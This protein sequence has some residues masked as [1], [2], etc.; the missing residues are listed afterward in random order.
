MLLRLFV[1]LLLL[2]M[3]EPG[4]A[5]S[6]PEQ[7]QP[8]VSSSEAVKENITHLP[9]PDGRYDYAT[10]D[11][12]TAHLYIA[13]GSSITDYN[14]KNASAPISLGQIA[15]GHAV[16]SLPRSSDLL[17]TSGDDST[18]R[19]LD[20]KSGHQTGQI[21]VGVDPDGAAIDADRN[22]AYVMNAKGG[23]VSVID[24]ASRK[25]M[26]TIVLKPGLEFPALG[27]NGILFVN[28]ENMNEIE[29]VDTREMRVEEAI[30]LSGCTG[31]SGLAYDAASDRLISAC[32]NGKAAIISAGNRKQLGLLDIGTKPDAVILDAQR[33]RAYI[34]CGGNG[35]LDEISL[36][37]VPAV[38]KRIPT[39]I[40]TRTGAM[41][42][43]TGELYLPSARFV[44]A[45]GIKHPP[46]IPGSFHVLI[47]NPDKQ[48]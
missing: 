23:T 7:P 9:G 16:L 32:A 28:N 15:H 34:P 36:A 30:A 13:R 29:I 4:S 33:R 41:D 40:G 25:V 21:S 35:E 5:A 24:L 38:L 47:I 48:N 6:L 37:S 22:I 8:Q 19:F 26:A 31:P 27:K 14:T 12:T 44:Q 43:R 3:A 45:P 17:V 2:A 10:F 18:V 39:E 20:K 42:S 11:E 1:A 46:M